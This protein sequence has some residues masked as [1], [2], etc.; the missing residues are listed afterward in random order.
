MLVVIAHP[1][2]ESFGLG[3][4]IGQFTAH[5]TAVHVLC[6]TRGEASTVNETGADLGRAPLV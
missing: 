5:G 6:Y 1:D 3:A 2:D 4:V